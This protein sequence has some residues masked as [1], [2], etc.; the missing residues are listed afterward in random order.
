[1]RA[2]G[3]SAAI[4][5]R[6][7]AEDATDLLAPLRALGLPVAFRSEQNTS[8]FRLDYRNGE[9]EMSI[10]ELGEPWRPDD[11]RGWLAETLRSADWVHAGALWRDDFPPETLA[12]LA[13][14]RR[15]ALEGHGLVRPGRTG[16]VVLDDEVDPGTLA[17][18]HVLHLAEDELAALGLTVDA[19]SLR[20]LAVR[21][22]VVTLGEQGSVVYAN[23][24]AQHVPARAL[25]GADPTG[26]GDSFMAAYL[27][28]RRRGHAPVSAARLATE[29]VHG[30]LSGAFSS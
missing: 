13:R 6:C 19:E 9:R 14:G 18:V 29:L 10:E 11:V 3:E 26:A 22:I 15:L 20:K 17:H 27:A 7:A 4:V 8:V 5:T 28:S 25:P 23:G 1:L 30:L 21:E 2:V 24:R 12:E 16:P